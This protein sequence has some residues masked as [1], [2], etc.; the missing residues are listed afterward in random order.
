M[1]KGKILL[2]VFIQCTASLW[3]SKKLIDE[4]VQRGKISADVRMSFIRLSCS[5]GHPCAI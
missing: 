1:V 5:Q 2:F 3:G 4:I